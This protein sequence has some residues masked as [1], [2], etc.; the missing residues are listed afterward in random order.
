MCL[1]GLL[2]VAPVN[3]QVQGK[4]DRQADQVS[5]TRDQRDLLILHDGQRISCVSNPAPHSR[6]G[7]DVAAD[8]L[9]VLTLR[10][11]ISRLDVHHVR[12]TALPFELELEMRAAHVVNGYNVTPGDVRQLQQRI[13]RRSTVGQCTDHRNFRRLVL[14]S[15]I[16]AHNSAGRSRHCH[17]LRFDVMRVMHSIVMQHSNANLSF[18]QSRSRSGFIEELD[19]KRL[20]END[21]DYEHDRTGKQGQ[22]FVG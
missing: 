1:A 16:L 7:V 13:L 20:R 11:V 10:L 19:G 8:I 22:C 18:L 9:D 21:T 2:G 12:I 5:K 4:L 3:C 17:G 15:G 14:G 6:A